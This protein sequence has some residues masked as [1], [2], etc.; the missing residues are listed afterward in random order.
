MLHARFVVGVGALVSNSLKEHTRR[1]LHTRSVV[2]VGA[3]V[4]YCELLLQTRSAVHS[5]FEVKE[6][7]FV[8]YWLTLH[9]RTMV[10][11]RLEVAVGALL[12][13]WMPAEQSVML[14][15]SR[16]VVA[17]GGFVS[18]WLALQL[19][20]V[21]TRSDVGVAAADSYVRVKLHGGVYGRHMRFCKNASARASYCKV[22]CG[23]ARKRACRKRGNNK[24]GRRVTQS[25]RKW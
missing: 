7:A 2:V 22:G 17:V 21:H 24:H 25:N 6:G 18:Y 9:A 10:H 4:W 3:V 12:I 8:S 5:R 23:R 1:S 19:S 20:G 11:S 14:A 16:W 13:N 15:Q